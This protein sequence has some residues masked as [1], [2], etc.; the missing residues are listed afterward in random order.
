MTA[1]TPRK[2]LYRVTVTHEALVWAESGSEAQKHAYN[3]CHDD[4]CADSAADLVK[5]LFSNEE[6]DFPYGRD[7]NATALQCL[8]VMQEEDAEEGREAR[9]RAAIEAH[10]T[11]ELEIA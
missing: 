4:G 11:L 3:I 10:P 2:R 8:R 5:T 7:D 6:K 1:T 9:E